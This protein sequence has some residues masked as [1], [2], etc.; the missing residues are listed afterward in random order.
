[1]LGAGLAGL[2]AAEELS[3]R[4]YRVTVLE[5][6]SV[7]GGLAAT[8]DQGQFRYDL[9]PHRFHT[10]NTEILD[11][12]GNLP[13]VELDELR[14][15][16]R[17]RLLDRYF[18]YPLSLGN[19]LSQMPLSRGMGMMGGFLYEK[20]RGVFAKREQNSFEG[21]VKSRFGR[22]LYELYLAPYN[23]KLWGIEPNTL[24]ADWASQRITV[25]SLA[26]LVRETLFPSKE[27]V[28]SLVGTFHY[29]RGGIGRISDGLVERITGAGGVVLTGTHPLSILHNGEEWKLILNEGY[30]CCDRII[31]TIPVTEYVQLLGGAMPDRIREA[32][33][34]LSFRALV[35]LSV[36]VSGEVKAR[37]HWIYTSEDRYPFNR[38][39]ISRNFDPQVPGQVVF[40]FSCTHGDGVWRSRGEELL[41][42]TIP[43]AEH[44]GLFKASQ[45]VGFHQSRASHAY[46]IYDLGYS[47]RAAAVLDAL[48]ELPRSVTCG[49]QGL[50]R[51]NNM[52][53]SIEMGR[54]AA[55]EIIGEAS[56]RER[57]SWD[58]NTWADG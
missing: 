38:L 50:F 22:G 48:E 49:R 1:V 55:L 32:A 36:M 47:R 39:S 21:W 27:T 7:T 51:Y 44:L 41:E 43:Q 6:E 33:A 26:G 52:D 12:V 25:P 35:F 34:G 45:V 16:S 8:I 14:R 40:E 58:E 11:F 57:F 13:G 23:R 31:N 15:V 3:R 54:Y 18:D 30:L 28:R 24:S 10:S 56:V 2:T 20:V 5:K 42:A 17:I 9:G 4:G 46:P 19:V 37:D 29:P 53:H